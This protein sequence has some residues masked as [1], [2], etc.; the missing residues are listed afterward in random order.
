MDSQA[1]RTHAAPDKGHRTMVRALAAVVGVGIVVTGLVTVP[2]VA[3]AS[4]LPALGVNPTTHLRPGVTPLVLPTFHHGASRRPTA[5]LTYYGGPVVSS[6]H[7]IDVSYG[8]VSYLT[9]NAAF[10]TSFT[11]QFLGS[12]VSDWLSDYDTPTQSIG[13]GTSGGVVTI[14]PSAQNDGTHVTDAEIQAELA[15]QIDTGQL[16]APTADT[17]YALFFQQGQSICDR[18]GSCS[19]V[20]G[21][22]CAYHGAMTANGV[23]FTYQ[24]MPDLTGSFGCGSGSDAQNTTSVLSHE[25]AETITDPDVNLAATYA[26]PLG[27]YDSSRG[28]IG[29]LCN[30]LQA[31]FVGTDGVTYTSQKLW[32]N[33]TAG[34]TET[35]LTAVAF[36]SASSASFTPGVAGAFAVVATGLPFATVVESGAL[37]AG[38]TYANGVLSGT[39]VA[40]SNGTY[41]LVFIATNGVGSPVVQSFTLTVPGVDVTTS[42]VPGATRGAPYTVQLV[43]AGGTTPYKWKKLTTLPKGLKLSSSGLLS[44]TPGLKD[45]AGPTTVSVQVTDATPKT[46]LV[47]TASFTLTL[48]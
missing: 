2:A 15:A 32:S 40:G 29:D 33:V 24:V 46:H 36:T 44:G 8:P 19:L 47:A 20:S 4:T 3:R 35:R 43:A 38:I 13:R 7:S 1:R 31:T 45:P 6:I 21:G 41:P 28:E 37:P 39:A 9:A 30:G 26:P 23:T 48:H 34:C 12:G 10:V 27:W 25:L 5:G 11:S 42:S 18:T 22:F 17:S 14:T 16:P